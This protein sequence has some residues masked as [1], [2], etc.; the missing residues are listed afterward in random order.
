MLVVCPD[1]HRQYD[2]EQCWPDCPHEPLFEDDGWM[3]D[4][5]QHG[6]PDIEEP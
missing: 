4:T 3:A 2:S 5:M 1:C 6:E